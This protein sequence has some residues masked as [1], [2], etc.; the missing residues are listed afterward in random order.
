MDALTTGVSIISRLALADIRFASLYA[1]YL[2]VF[3][4]AGR[5]T[6]GAASLEH[7][8]ERAGRRDW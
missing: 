5:F 1:K 7:L 8:V 3:V 6:V 2:L 4:D